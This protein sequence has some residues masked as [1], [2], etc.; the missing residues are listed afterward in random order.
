MAP[1]SIVLLLFLIKFN[2]SIE[3]R[4]IIVLSCF[5]NLVTSRERSVPP[6]KIFALG[7]FFNIFFKLTIVFGA[8]YIFPLLFIS[9]STLL[10]FFNKL[11]VLF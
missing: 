1:I 6:L 5:L 3:L 11:I 10:I 7:Y 4:E 9:T 2:F 8:K